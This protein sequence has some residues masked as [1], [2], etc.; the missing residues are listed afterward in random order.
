MQPQS[1]QQQTT[2]QP[3]APAPV[4][5]V[6]LSNVD[7][8]A[9]HS[10]EGIE[11]AIALIAA[12]GFS[13]VFPVVWNR[14][15]TLF[16]SRTIE[17]LLGPELAIAPAWRGRDPLAEIVSAAER[18]GLQVIPWFEY[19]FAGGH[20]IQ[21]GPLLAVRPDWAARNRQQ[22]LVRRNGFEWLNGFDPAVQEFI[23]DLILEVVRTY[24]VAG[25]QGDD[26]LPAQPVQAGHDP[27]T[28]AAYLA[29]TGRRPG[30]DHDAAWT[31]WRCDQLTGF[32]LRLRQRIKAVRPDCLLSLAPGPHPYARREYLQDWP[33]WLDQGL[34]DLLHPQLYLRGP[35][36]A[37]GRLL[38]HSLSAA[39]VQADP[40]RRQRLAP[41]LLLKVGDHVAS[42]ERI[43]Q[44]IEANRARS[45]NGEVLFHYEGLVANGAA[46]ARLLQQKGYGRSGGS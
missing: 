25:I 26:R 17:A 31:S 21:G 19:G 36:W 16:P 6:W 7:C 5:G 20:T 11:T 34:V 41:G 2:A 37:Y 23:S 32:L 29:T 39:G 13:H 30:R 43:W 14:G 15:L 27:A 40:S 33:S 1:M 28:V 46:C 9:F 3:P 35:A 4:R 10:R 22:Q 44:C 24:P 45:V 38:D 12:T 18:H 8:E 42:P